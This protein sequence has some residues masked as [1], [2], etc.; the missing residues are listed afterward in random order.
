EETK[1]VIG[2]VGTGVMG[3]SMVKNLQAA[4][5]T[6]NIYTRTK[7]KAEPVIES[8]AI[9]KETVAALAR[10]ADVIITM[11][12]YPEDV[13]AIYIGDKGIR[14]RAKDGTYLVDM[15]TSSPT[16]A[17]EI[18]DEAKKHNLHALDAPVSGG[19]IGAKN[20]TLTIM[21]GGDE[22]PFEAVLPVFKVLGENIILQGK[23]GAGQ[24]TKLANQITIATNMIGVCEAIIY[25][26]HAGLDPSRMLD[27]I[28]AGAAGSWSLSNLG[29]RMIKGDYA[30]GFFVK[31]FIKDMKIAIESAKE[32]GISTP[33][34]ELS[35]RLYEELSEMGEGDSG[36]QALIKLL[37]RN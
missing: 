15:T 17:E 1:P 16:L 26:K 11:V 3:S 8:G 19:D 37:E 13:K 33:G 4:A 36:T 31:H 12:G 9:E 2:F 24:H 6:V 21:V 23:A 5:Y 7:Q 32:M 10:S 30:P 25:A 28:E 14:R 34:L 35:L 27:S 22:A 18:Y 20:G 29:R